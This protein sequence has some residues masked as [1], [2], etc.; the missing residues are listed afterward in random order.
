MNHHHHHQKHSEHQS[1]VLYFSPFTIDSLNSTIHIND[2]WNLIFF[3]ITKLINYFIECLSFYIHN[4]MFSFMLYI[5]WYFFELSIVSENVCLVTLTSISVTLCV[6]QLPNRY[7][8]YQ[9]SH[10]RD[11][12]LLPCLSLSSLHCYFFLF[13]I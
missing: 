5:K 11:Y 3:R 2:E 10:F 1:S 7:I 8:K 12:C 9:I 13:Y 4:I 6:K